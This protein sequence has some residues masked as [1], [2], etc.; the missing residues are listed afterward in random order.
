MR[1]RVDL[2]ELIHSI[3][4]WEETIECW[5]KVLLHYSQMLHLCSSD[6]LGLRFRVPFILIYLNRDDDAYAFCQNWENDVYAFRLHWENL[7]TEDYNQWQQH[8]ENSK[9]GGWVFPREDGCRYNDLF[10]DTLPDS[11][12]NNQEHTSSGIFGGSLY[13][14]GASG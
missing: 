13:H 12:N 6:N 1:A 7:E 9:E 2:A 5:E 4:Y 11:H 3:A 10:D 8:H 14:Q